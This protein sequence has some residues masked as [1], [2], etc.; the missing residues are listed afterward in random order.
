MQRQHRAVTI[1]LAV[2]AFTLPHV[3]AQVTGI[4]VTAGPAATS[5]TGEATVA[6]AIDSV[7]LAV[8]GHAAGSVSIL[9]I[10]VSCSDAYDVATCIAAVQS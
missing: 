3:H 10:L 2:L 9:P 8:A 4:T 6:T 5:Y 7:A 1:L